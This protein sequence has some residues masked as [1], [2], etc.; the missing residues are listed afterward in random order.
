MAW[1]KKTK[2]VI[3][4]LENVTSACRYLEGHFD[5]KA[6]GG[7]KVAVKC[8]EIVRD[9]HAEAKTIRRVYYEQGDL[10]EK[11][12]KKEKHGKGED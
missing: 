8:G 11:P 5:V 2:S 7:E 4:L 1:D 3:E 6:D 9:L 10:F 12:K